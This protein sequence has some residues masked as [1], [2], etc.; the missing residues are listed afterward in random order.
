VTQGQALEQPGLEAKMVALPLSP[1]ILGLSRSKLTRLV[2]CNTCRTRK[3]KCDEQHPYCLE[4]TR[5]GKECTYRSNDPPSSVSASDTPSSRSR[6]LEPRPAQDVFGGLFDQTYT[7]MYPFMYGSDLGG[8]KDPHNFLPQTP[9]ISHPCPV[10]ILEEFD[11]MGDVNFDFPS[12]NIMNT[13]H[14]D[15]LD[16]PMAPNNQFPNYLAASPQPGRALF[17]YDTPLPNGLKISY[18]EHQAIKHYES[19]FSLY[20][21][22]KTPD[23]STHKVLF[24][25]GE[26]N[27]MIMHLLLAVSINDCYL[28]RGQ[29]QEDLFQNADYHYEKGRLLFVDTVQKNRPEDTLLL[30]AAFFFLYLYLSK[31]KDVGPRRLRILSTNVL[32]FIRSHRLVDRCIS[33]S[34]LPVQSAAHLKHQEIRKERSVLS[35]LIIWT[36]DEDIKCSFQ[37][38]GGHLA[39]YLV[40]QGSRTK[41]VYETSRNALGF[42]FAE[43]YPYRE[44]TDDRDNTM[45]LEFLYAL[46]PLWQAINDLNQDSEPIPEETR[47]RVEHQFV[48]L[49]EVSTESSA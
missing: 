14:S 16:Y 34:S 41:E 15:A 42:F 23:W 17:D 11:P 26:E 20:R 8:Y 30:M 27:K 3:V 40:A 24:K 12:G 18:N 5:L 13:I 9:F 45:T 37:G 25:M 33:T 49:E 10:P 46:M 36:Y 31:R 6:P 21:T 7:P 47:R 35:R 39:R 4:C 22:T 1:G 44:S 48:A 29:M 38:T 19:T 43:R 28:R 32:E 2:G